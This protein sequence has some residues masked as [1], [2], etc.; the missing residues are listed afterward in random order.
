MDVIGVSVLVGISVFCVSDGLVDGSE[1]VIGFSFG[2]VLTS[3]VFMIVWVC[4]CITFS[5]FGD[6]VSISMFFS[7]FSICCF[8]E[9]PMINNRTAII[10]IISFTIKTSNIEIGYQHPDL[11]CFVCVDSMQSIT[12]ENLICQLIKI[13]MSTNYISVCLNL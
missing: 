2:G 5:C 12:K 13:V 6:F 11:I 7:G 4:F 3:S 1:G 8:V 10:S 9:Q